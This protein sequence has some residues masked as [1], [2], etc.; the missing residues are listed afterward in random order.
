MFRTLKVDDIDAIDVNYEGDF[1]RPKIKLLFSSDEGDICN[2]IITNRTTK[3]KSD[4]CCYIES[5]QGGNKLKFPINNEQTF[6]IINKNG[7]NYIP[8]SVVRDVLGMEVNWD[9]KNKIVTITGKTNW[10]R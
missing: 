9:N 1:N 5:K 10:R 7:Y 3:N 4:F 2:I 8:L 6:K